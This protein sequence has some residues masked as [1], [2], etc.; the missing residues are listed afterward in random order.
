MPCNY[1]DMEAMSWRTSS[2]T[3]SKLF[4]ENKINNTTSDNNSTDSS[5]ASTKNTAKDMILNAGGDEGTLL[6]Y[7]DVV[8]EC[9]HRPSELLS[10][11][12]EKTETLRL[13]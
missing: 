3:L 12:L 4:L 6:T 11:I 7:R 13:S 1:Y 5:E 9:V 10:T 8:R 2:P